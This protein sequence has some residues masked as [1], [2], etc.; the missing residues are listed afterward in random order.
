MDII[1]Q[2]IIGLI[3]NFIIL[4]ISKY[5]FAFK[6]R[7][8]IDDANYDCSQNQITKIKKQ[9]YICFPIGILLMILSHYVQ[10]SS[11]LMVA[12]YVF[13]FWMFLFALFAF[14]CAIEVIKNLQKSG[15][16]I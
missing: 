9:F 13:A 7:I 1:N 2:V 12:I 16:N 8:D 14:M 11:L 10:K 5:V 3:A 15:S 6:N 4:L